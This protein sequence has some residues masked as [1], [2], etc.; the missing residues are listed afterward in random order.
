MEDLDL[1]TTCG[2]IHV[3][4]QGNGEKKIILLHGSGCD[5]AM[6]SWREVMENFSD[7]FTVYAPDQL[8]YG[9]KRQARK[10]GGGQLLRYPH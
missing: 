6:L 4:K 5:S 10:Y 1:K 7:K 2:N 8:G 3:Y 9:K